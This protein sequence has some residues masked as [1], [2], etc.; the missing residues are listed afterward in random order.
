[1]V[2]VKA[3]WDIAGK[4]KIRMDGNTPDGCY[5][6]VTKATLLKRGT[7]YREFSVQSVYIQGAIPPGVQTH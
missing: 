4:T 5:A 1:M 6:V 2:A 3:V 7:L